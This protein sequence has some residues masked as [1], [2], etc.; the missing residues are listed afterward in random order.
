MIRR[1]PAK[2]S[3]ATA[4]R[5]TYRER[6]LALEM[7]E[8]RHMLAA[9]LALLESGLDQVVVG[10]QTKISNEVFGNS[11]PLVGAALKTAANAAV[12]GALQDLLSASGSTTIADVESELQSH[13]SS[14][15]LQPITHSGTDASA[16]ITFNIKLGKSVEFNV[17]FNT[18]L[19][20][21]G[22]S[23][24]GDVKVELGVV[25]ETQIGVDGTGF[26]VNTAFRSG[27]TAP[28]LTFSLTVTAPGLTASG[29]F[30]LLKVVATDQGS[31]LA[32][33][34][35]VDLVDTVDGGGKL[36]LANLGALDA[37]T[38]FSATDSVIN[39][40]LQAEFGAGS[41]INPKLSANLVVSWPFND[42]NPESPLASF[43]SAPTIEMKNVGI[44]A[45]SLFQSLVA[46]LVERMSDLAEPFVKIVDGLNQQVFPNQDL[47]KL[48][49]LDLYKIASAKSGGGDVDGA[50]ITQLTGIVDGFGVGAG[51]NEDFA[52][53]DLVVKVVDLWKAAKQVAATG[54]IP[55]GD[56]KI[57]DPR[58]IAPGGVLGI[59]NPNALT[60]AMGQLRNLAGSFF[61]LADQFKTSA[62]GSGSGSGGVFRLDIMEDTNNAF[63]LFV[64]DPTAQVF[65]FNLP[66]LNKGFYADYRVNIFLFI[67]PVTFGFHGGITFDAS[68]KGG[69]DGEGL[70]KFRSSGDPVDILDGFY[71]DTT[72]P[73][74]T[75][76]GRDSLGHDTDSLFHAD[77][78]LGWSD[79]FSETL[80]SSD[81]GFNFGVSLGVSGE[82]LVIAGDLTA[83]TADSGKT[84]VE[85]AFSDPTPSD[86]KLRFSDMA[87]DVNEGLECLF[88]I[89]GGVDWN[90]SL[91]TRLAAEL[92]VAVEVE[93]PTPF[94]D[95]DVGIS[96]EVEVEPVN[97]TWAET[98]GELFSLDFECAD[99][100]TASQLANAVLAKKEGDG[101]L[102]LLVGSRANE[103]NLSPDEINEN[104]V[105]RHDGGSPTDSG[106]ESVTVYAFGGKQSFTGIKSI[107]ADA[108]D[109]NDVI[110]IATDVLSPAVL[111]GGEGEDQLTLS[112]AG[113]FLYGG[114]D[115]DLL[116][117][118]TG[119]DVIS[120]DGGDDELY[121]RDGNDDLFGGAD[122]DLINGE[123]GDDNM[124]GDVGNDRF[125][126]GA[127]VD[128]IRE[129]ANVDFSLTNNSLTGLGTDTLSQVEKAVLDGGVGD[130]VFT[131][132][133]WNGA[134]TLNAAS[135][136]DTYLVTFNTGT[137]GTVAIAD[138][139]GTSD[140][141]E[142]RGTIF[143]DTINVIT[144]KVSRGAQ[145]VTYTG[146]EAVTVDGRQENDNI[147]V[148][149]TSGA[150]LTVIGNAG[151]DIIEIGLGNLGAIQA[152]VTVQ[153]GTNLDKLI[154]SDALDTTATTGKLAA[155][156]LTGLGIGPDGITYDAAS[157]DVEILL[158]SGS[159]D[160]LV[161]AVLRAR[162][163]GRTGTTIFA[164]AGNDLISVGS[165]AATNQGDLDAIQTKLI[166]VGGGDSGGGIEA[167]DRIYVNDRTKVQKFNYKL[168][169]TALTDDPNLTAAPARTFDGLKYDSTTE[170][171]RLDG[172]DAANQFDVGPSSTTK[173][174]IDGNLPAPGTVAPDRGDFLKLDTKT[175]PAPDRLLGITS[176][177]S[178]SWTFPV[179]HLQ[180]VQFESIEKFN[181][182]D[183]VAVGS[184][185]ASKGASKPSF[186]VYDAENNRFK[187]RVAASSTYGTSDKYGIRL[188]VAD[189]DGDGLPDVI[190]A[191]GRS[192]KPDIKVFL[193]TPQAGLQGKLYTT[194]AASD[195]FGTKFKDG[196]N[197]TA[198]DVDGDAMPEVI[199]APE[200]GAATIKIYHNQ[201]LEPG[202]PTAPLKTTARNLNAFSDIKKYAGGATLAVGNLDGD[203]LNI[204]ELIVGTGAGVAGKVRTFSLLAA[205]PVTLRT[206]NDPT[207]FNQGIFVSAGNVDGDSKAEIVTA[208]G[209]GGGSRIRV[210]SAAGVQLNS[211]QAFSTADV[212][213]APL[214]ITMRDAN[215]DGRADI[216][217]MQGQDGRSNYR[218]KKFD[219][220]TGSIVDSLFA[221]DS[222][223]AGG[224]VNLG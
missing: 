166:I 111:Y 32:G 163:V 23:A 96:F 73:F 1:R 197:I 212:P 25:L 3:R 186:D 140:K 72:D 143:A 43:G 31:K 78:G 49:Y 145:A 172:T 54:V 134:A 108:G 35:K 18:G 161:E 126:G 6:I 69:F 142:V 62:P 179:T 137:T 8:P 15:L 58:P 28:E 26:F 7:L 107:L 40:G 191:P 30:G 91:K 33:T 201:V 101:Q 57:S 192:T 59:V 146:I 34:F 106:G 97:H 141:L 148:G 11:L 168:T 112:N 85:F 80:S 65:T 167:R 165:R 216:F 207:G 2:P 61:A 45:G 203:G 151:A 115:R 123:G 19:A 198:G 153:G 149:S 178:G 189:I 20:A 187:F 199:L 204:L 129:S 41:A 128:T 86:H 124:T 68:L 79:E 47:I 164:G 93:I 84:G 82:I 131:V 190:T 121:G 81:L 219:A 147:K 215:D 209:S 130:N 21:L 48:T 150:P 37:Q 202:H 188:A 160:F 173:Y 39:L 4:K 95:A 87:H 24:S 196:V 22:L 127:G 76:R 14:V 144:G 158:G 169:P 88:D 75:L 222:D 181:H 36:R 156:K 176:R 90:V 214:R 74:M 210:F 218:L 157:D 206:I 155:G 174:F 98:G 51:K 211:F 117:G 44:D 89:S 154:A 109:G 180:D 171:F 175:I 184:D 223:F 125:F 183:I 195:T 116:Y 138:S 105:V 200:R 9:N 10:I 135:G 224:G 50:G 16:E 208:T 92:K 100:A 159:D 152:A 122:N 13:L 114:A 67:V 29:D 99:D 133:S 55:L 139:A 132:S 64:G 94:G 113:G 53:L 42:A 170:F 63:K 194:L 177:G 66:K 119:R 12:V 17:P 56:F 38:Q 110:E 70:A 118:G 27:F 213:N 136:S 120:G 193:G 104:V 205:T 103:R 5:R 46:P 83:K 217:A 60:G 185:V 52:F 102:V 162:Q 71:L 77:G 221:T 220:L 182:V